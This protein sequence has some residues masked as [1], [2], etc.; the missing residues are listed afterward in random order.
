MFDAVSPVDPMNAVLFARQ[1][2]FRLVHPFQLIAISQLRVLTL[3]I[4]ILWL[5]RY[6]R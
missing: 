3:M 5:F 4:G 1:P 2:R 6:F